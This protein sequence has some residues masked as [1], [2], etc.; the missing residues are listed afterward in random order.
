MLRPTFAL[1]SIVLALAAASCRSGPSDERREEWERGALIHKTLT[2][3]HTIVSAHRGKVGFLKIYDVTEG[4]GNPYPWKYVYDADWHELGWVDQFGGAV[5]YH[6]Y[7]PSEQAFQKLELRG[8]KLPADSLENNVMRMLDIDPSTDRLTFPVST[9][10]DITGDTGA[11]HVAG[12]G[13]TPPTVVPE[14]APAK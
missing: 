4:G 13:I 12:P 2:G 3:Y 7:S 6:V 5:K 11:P 9:T 10:Q 8:D 14:K 1:A